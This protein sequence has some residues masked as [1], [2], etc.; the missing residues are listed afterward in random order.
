M[1]ILILQ[2]SPTS[3]LIPPPA[4]TP[5]VPKIQYE[6]SLQSN[7]VDFP[8][9]VSRDAPALKG[10]WRSAFTDHTE[11]GNPFIYSLSQDTRIVALFAEEFDA[12][13]HASSTTWQTGGLISVPVPSTSD[14]LWTSTAWRHT[15]S[16][17]IFIARCNVFDRTMQN[18]HYYYLGWFHMPRGLISTGSISVDMNRPV[19]SIITEIQG[20]YIDVYYCAHSIHECRQLVEELQGQTL[21]LMFGGSSAVAAQFQSPPKRM[22]PA[23]TEINPFRS[24]SEGRDHPVLVQKELGQQII[25]HM[26]RDKFLLIEAPP[27]SGKSTL[28]DDVAFA[29]MRRPDSYAIHILED[30]KIDITSKSHKQVLLYSLRCAEYS[31]HLQGNIQIRLQAI[32]NM[33][34]LS[35]FL[36]SEPS[37]EFEFWIFVNEAQR[38]YDNAKLWRTLTVPHAQQLFVIAAG[39]YSS[40]TG[41]A[42]HSPP[43]EYI[44]KSR[45]INLFP[46]GEDDTLC[47]AFKE[48]DF[49]EFL[50]LALNTTGCASLDKLLH[51]GVAVELTMY[52]LSKLKKH[53]TINTDK[54]FTDF[55]NTCLDQAKDQ[56]PY[57]LGRCVPHLPMHDRG[58]TGPALVVFISVLLESIIKILP[59]DTGIEKAVVWNTN[60]TYIWDRINRSEF[61]TASTIPHWY[62]RCSNDALYNSDNT[63]YGTLDGLI[64]LGKIANTPRARFLEVAAGE[65]LPDGIKPFSVCEC[66][67]SEALSDYAQAA[68]DARRM[69]WLLQDWHTVNGK[70]QLQLPTQWHREHLMDLLVPKDLPKE[71]ETMDFD[72][73]LLKVISKLRPSVLLQAVHEGKPP[74]KVIYDSEFKCAADIV[75][76]PLFLIPQTQTDSGN[77]IVDFTCLK[78]CWAIELMH[79]RDKIEEHFARFSPDGAYHQQWPTWDWRIVD[80]HFQH[81]KTD[82]VIHENYRVV[83]LTQVDNSQCM[84]ATIYGMGSKQLVTLME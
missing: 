16:K 81:T 44:L 62:R 73:F 76:T 15:Q 65:H 25:E 14:S 45:R 46:S 37:L 30:Y 58:F 19:S 22:Q 57:G 23:A 2:S 84:Q 36:N 17:S 43:R 42:A 79:E 55:R 74:R 9:F 5:A 8:S 31:M 7:N 27:C 4:V 11:K 29:V 77:G 35:D 24:C 18:N 78:R 53:G 70:L 38:V 50:G 1:T 63:T 80:F 71:V 68:H 10:I 20:R 12:Q 83:H 54:L 40:H 41:S 26:T 52:L 47:V 64:T 69:G 6:Q 72:L 32:E 21:N 82:V 61:L 33:T 28:L 51:P 75:A 59:I 48:S 56:E 67:T 39:S 49:D 60:S 13:Y 66:S 34:D 3:W